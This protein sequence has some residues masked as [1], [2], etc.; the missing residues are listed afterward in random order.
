MRVEHPRLIVRLLRF[1]PDVISPQKYNLAVKETD[2]KLLHMPLATYKIVLFSLTRPSK[3][4]NEMVVKLL[5][6]LPFDPDS[7]AI[8]VKISGKIHRFDSDCEV[9]DS[10][11]IP[12]IELDIAVC[13]HGAIPLERVFKGKNRTEL[14]MK[15]FQEAEDYNRK[16]PVVDYYG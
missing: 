8:F 11:V 13:K 9:S 5:A 7:I 1:G 6:Y 4:G 15:C 12:K 10:I 16:Y 14:L 2:I 3:G